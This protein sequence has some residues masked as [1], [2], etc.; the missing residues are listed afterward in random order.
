MEEAGVRKGWTIVRIVPRPRKDP[1]QTSLVK[2]YRP[3][4]VYWFLC[5]EV[6][7]RMG[8]AFVMFGAPHASSCL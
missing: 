2:T 6:T 7:A 1:L 4:G 8:I 5:F 3:H